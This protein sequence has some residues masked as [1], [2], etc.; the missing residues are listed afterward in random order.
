MA[1]GQSAK[2]TSMI[3]WIQT[4][5]LSIKISLSLQVWLGVATPGEE[6]KPSRQLILYI[7]NDKG[8]V[9]GFVR[10]LTFERRLYRHFL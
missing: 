2:I 9:D 3:K 7:S 4:S 5:R 1:Q 8:Q 10:E 6:A